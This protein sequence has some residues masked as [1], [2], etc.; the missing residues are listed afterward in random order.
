MRKS[1]SVSSLP[2]LLETASI[3]SE[4]STK[5]KCQCGQRKVNKRK[6][7]RRTRNSSVSSIESLSSSFS[8][9]SRESTNFH[10]KTGL[11]T[12]TELGFRYSV[13]Y[14]NNGSQFRPK[15]QNPTSD[16]GAAHQAAQLPQPLCQP[17]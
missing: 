7:K 5:S 12:S 16:P 2:Q 13:L 10:V 14:Q 17:P 8:D 9:N 1:K 4:N 3:S 15:R 11:S 6:S